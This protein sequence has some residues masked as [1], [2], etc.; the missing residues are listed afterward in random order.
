MLDPHE[1]R[2]LSEWATEGLMPDLT[3]LFDLPPEV[4]RRRLDG[5]RTRYDRLEAEA[6]AFHDRVR[7]A[8]L[9]A[10][11]RERFVKV[12]EAPPATK[13]TSGTNLCLIYPTIDRRG[14]KLV[15]V[16]CLDNLVKGASGQAIQNMNQMLGYPE[17]TGLDAVALFP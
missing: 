10:Y 13:H 15:V 12:V 7:A 1:V 3:L 4:A 11:G 9:E 8:Y 2:R 16:S 17:E 6:E 14:G 5:V